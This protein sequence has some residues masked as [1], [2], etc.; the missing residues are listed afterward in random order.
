MEMNDM[1]K[2]LV[3]AEMLNVYKDATLIQDLRDHYRKDLIF[4]ARDALSLMGEQGLRQRL[5]T[6]GVPSRL[7][8]VLDD[9]ENFLIVNFPEVQDDDLEEYEG[10]GLEFVDDAEEEDEA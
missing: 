1:E 2:S 7:V 9:I 10:E 4:N 6:C 5:M 3:G 8:G